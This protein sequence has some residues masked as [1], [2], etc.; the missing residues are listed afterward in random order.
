[1]RS[2]R[3]GRGEEPS[4]FIPQGLERS[5]GDHDVELWE[6]PAESGSLGAGY[7][8]GLRCF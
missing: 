4:L 7:E 3:K 5:C 1:M 8:L 6:N 2:V